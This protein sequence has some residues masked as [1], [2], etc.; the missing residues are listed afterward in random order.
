[1]LDGS[2]AFVDPADTA[3][4]L[5][6]GGRQSLTVEGSAATPL[7][8]AGTLGQLRVRADAVSDGPVVLTVRIDG[9]DTSLTCA[10]A[11]GD[12]S[13]TDGVH[14]VAFAAGAAVAVQVAKPGG[15]A[16]RHLRFTLVVAGP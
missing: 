2:V 1:V 9:A 14:A 13:C 11:A 3:G 6:L 16:L 5:G 10:L 15:S 7:G 4:F 8:S 12:T